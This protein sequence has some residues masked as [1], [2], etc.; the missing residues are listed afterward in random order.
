MGSPP[1][2]CGPLT[3]LR[4][5]LLEKSRAIRQAKDECSF[6][7]FYQLLGGAGEQLKGQWPLGGGGTGT[8]G[9]GS[10]GSPAGRERETLAFAE[11][12]LR[13]GLLARSGCF[14]VP[15]PTD[16]T[17]ASREL[18]PLRAAPADSAASGPAVAWV[19]ITPG[20]SPCGSCS[21]SLLFCSLQR[22]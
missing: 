16:P 4:P 12:L 8:R 2:A 22:V 6:H 7:I 10:S 14:L 13:V 17:V 15:G 9:S 20:P 21:H 3:R 18:H 5:D 1:V 19:S 11:P